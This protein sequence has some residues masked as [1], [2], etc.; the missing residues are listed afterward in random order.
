M[1]TG[2]VVL[3][4]MRVSYVEEG[5]GRP[6]LYIHGNT[7]SSLWFSKAM[8]VPGRRCIA[9]DMP[10]FGRSDPLA[11]EPDIH[12]YADVVAQFMD[13]LGIAP[14]PVA[15]HSLG[16][17]VAQSLAVRHPG[18]ASALVLVDSASPKGLLTPRD[19]HPLIEMIRKDR[20][21]LSKAL[22]ATV[23][24]LKD[25]EFFE[26]LVEEARLMAAP[27]WIGNAEALCRFD[28]GEA[29]REVRVPVLVL[30]GEGD[31]LVTRAMAEETAAAYPNS[32]LEVVKG[33]GHSVIAEDPARFVKILADF[34]GR[35]EPGAPE[36]ASKKRGE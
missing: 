6:M 5:E 11:G 8:A 24:S 34:L 21:I 29:P 4:G 17:A 20:A 7:G 25:Q 30:W 18:A 10:N 32:R 35:A 9:L 33:V 3:K 1:K 19:R 13:F 31:F 26:A 36:G 12:A 15:G 2:S 22:A 23:P 14:A 16:G 28:L 27:A